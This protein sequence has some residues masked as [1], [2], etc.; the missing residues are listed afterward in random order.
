MNIE[1]NDNEYRQ[2]ST[3]E[4]FR[5]FTFPQ[6]YGNFYNFYHSSELKYSLFI[7]GQLK[8]KRRM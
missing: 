1:N 6:Y 8:P 2:D 5:F 4:N 3:N 7:L